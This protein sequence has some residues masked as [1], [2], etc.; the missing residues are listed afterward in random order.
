MPVIERITGYHDGLTRIRRDIHRHPELGYRET[1]TS[2]LV[3]RELASYGIEVHRGLAKTGVVGRLKVGTGSRTI[4]LRA[5]M[6]ALPILEE[7]TFAHRSSNDGVMHACGHDG[8]TTMLLG[9]ARYLA[10]TR[11][12]DG[13]VHFIFQPA[14]EGGGGA[15]VMI[16][17]GLFE[18]FPCDQVFGMH[19][20]ATTPV[21]LFGIRPGPT[22][23][24]SGNFDL[25]IA[26]R[27]AHAARP[28]SGVDPV[29]VAANTVMALQTIA[30]RNTSATDAVVV[31][32]TAIHGGPAD[33][34]AAP[35]SNSGKSELGYNIIPDAVTLRGNVR[36]YKP[37]IADRLG[38]TIKRIADGVASTYGATAE[39]DFRMLYPPLVNHEKETKIAGDAAAEVVGEANV[40][41]DVTP[42]MASEDF[43]YMLQK[44]PGAFIFIGNAAESACDVHNPHY[45]FNDSIIPTGSSF[46]VR[47]VERQLKKA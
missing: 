45:D 20:A 15:R 41:R 22:M 34:I 5:D 11:N 7:N 35:G 9:A 30:S 23:A 3:A 33:A 39:L 14:E 27:G 6:D 10:E 8:H 25:R 28:E 24:G 38:P 2:E 36:A 40:N 43:S 31:S 29:V 37:E 18:Q 44:R 32:V 12:F 1:R 16:E 21:G 4:G 42:R 47:L 13:T 19:N 46:F 17:E 26:G